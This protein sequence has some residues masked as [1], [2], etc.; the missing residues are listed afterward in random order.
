[1]VSPTPLALRVPLREIIRRSLLVALVPGALAAQATQTVPPNDPVYAFID[2]LVAARLVDT[3]IVGQ[4]SMSRREVGHILQSSTERIR[5]IHAKPAPTSV[6]EEGKNA[7]RA[8]LTWLLNHLEDYEKAFPDS[9]ETAPFTAI[10]QLQATLLDSPSRGIGPDGNGAIDVDLNP[11]A[12]NQLGQSTFDGGSYS[13]RLGAGGALGRYLAFNATGRVDAFD[14]RGGGSSSQGQVDQL[15]L[16]GLW[17]NLGILVGRDYL[18]FGQGVNAG[19]MASLNPRG[20]DQV[21]LASDHPFVMPWLLR[22]LGPAQATIALGDLGENQFFPHTRFLG[23]KLSVRPH[24]R[25]EIG[26]GLV[27][28]VGGQGAPGGTF[29]QK[30]EDAFPLLDA[31]I[32]HRRMEFGNKFVGVDLRYTLPWVAG[33]QFYAEGAFD[34]FD[35]RRVKSTFTEDAGYIWGLSSSCLATC[36]RVRL[37]TEYHVT[38]VRYYTHGAFQ[39]GFTVDEQFIGDPLGPRARGAYGIVDVDGRRASHRLDFAYED[40]SGNLYG[41]MTS[42]TD[43]SDFHFVVI[44]RRPAERRWRAVATEKLGGVNDRVAFTIG[45]GAE[46]VENFNHVQ[47]SWKTNG[48]LQLGLQYRPTR[49]FF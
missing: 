35:F 34:D 30:V 10:A 14:F 19:L 7:E 31:L 38:G 18:F 24:P 23:Y 47:G 3:V 5:Q 15:Y 1:L 41:S 46:R 42:T 16:R 13:L 29:A 8:E 20:I 44:G 32:L 49:P 6:R 9:L 26:A 27:E 28:Q 11:L 43:D 12:S 22:Y 36:G 33:A 25:F 2:R 48:L 40:R 45:A 4:R 21:R 37:S 17:K 39:S